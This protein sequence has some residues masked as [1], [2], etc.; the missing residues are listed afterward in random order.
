MRLGRWGR[1]ETWRIDALA[2]LA[3]PPNII[4]PRTSRAGVSCEKTGDSFLLDMD[5]WLLLIRQAVRKNSL[6]HVGPPSV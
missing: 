6:A 4:P 3:S 2:V 1:G 5:L